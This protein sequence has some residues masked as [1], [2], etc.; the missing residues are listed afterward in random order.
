MKKQTPES[1]VAE[2]AQRIKLEINYWN[3]LYQFGGSDPFWPDGTGLNLTRNHIISYK[4]GIHKLCEEYAL[5]IHTEADCPT[6]REVDNN[7]MAHADLIRTKAE[8]TL[9]A[10]LNDSSYKGLIK[11]QYIPF[12]TTGKRLFHK[13]NIRLCE[14]ASASNCSG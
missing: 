14:M 4:M 13:Q 3:Q 6:P 1:Q 10:Y 5:P 12:P 7:Y 8:E 9:Q 2:Y 11:L